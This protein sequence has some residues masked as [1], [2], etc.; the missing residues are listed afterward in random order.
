MKTIMDMAFEAGFT[1]RELIRAVD[2]LVAFAAIVAAA[3]RQ[4]LTVDCLGLALDLEKQ[5][6]R[7]E[8][9]TVQRAMLTAATGL[10]NI[11]AAHCIGAKP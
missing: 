6:K 1:E 8:S 2:C 7:V 9:Q 10:R 5:S 11:E 3:E 4:R